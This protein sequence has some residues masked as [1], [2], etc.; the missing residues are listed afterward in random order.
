MC[1]VLS[2][3]AINSGLYVDSQIV[4]TIVKIVSLE[5][6]LFINTSALLLFVNIT[7]PSLLKDSVKYHFALDGK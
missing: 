7:A 5:G 3:L 1:N 2:Y 6:V 4:L